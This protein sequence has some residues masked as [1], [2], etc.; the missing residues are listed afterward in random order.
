MDIEGYGLS[1]EEASRLVKKTK[2]NAAEREKMDLAH[3]VINTVEEAKPVLQ[4]YD[5]LHSLGKYASELL[6]GMALIKAGKNI[7]LVK[8]EFLRES[9][10]A[11]TFR[12]DNSRKAKILFRVISKNKLFMMVIHHFQ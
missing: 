6:S 5:Q 11:L 7:G 8:Q 9:S 12:I 10:Q 4:M 2:P 1:Y 3:L